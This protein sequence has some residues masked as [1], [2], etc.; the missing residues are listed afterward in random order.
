MRIKI[1]AN[2]DSLLLKTTTKVLCA[3][4]NDVRPFGHF[5]TIPERVQLHSANAMLDERAITFTK[6]GDKRDR[7]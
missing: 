7:A 3:V 2:K 4:T 5:H 1:G 6:F